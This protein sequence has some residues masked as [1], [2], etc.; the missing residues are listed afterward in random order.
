MLYAIGLGLDAR[1]HLTPEAMRAV[2]SCVE[3]FVLA[4]D[5]SAVS[6]VRELNPSAH[7]VDCQKFYRNRRRRPAVYDSIAE[8][9]LQ[10]CTKYTDTA[11]VV[12][13]HPMFLVSAVETLLEG[14][15]E[16]GVPTKVIPGVSSLDMVMADLQLDVGY[17]VTVADATLLLKSGLRLDTRLPL[18]VFQIANVGSD[19]VERG[20]IPRDRLVEVLNHLQETY[21]DDHDCILVV[22]QKSLLDD[23]YMLRSTLEELKHD[24]TVRLEDR[25]TL[26]LPGLEE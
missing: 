5:A 21:P 4:P 24:R 22:S 15:R 10:A 2:R 3:I 11:L 6:L 13:G 1:A 7:V 9:V 17:G 25:P 18:L 12:Y 16:I 19:R 23:G 20:A 26:F 8:A 14:A